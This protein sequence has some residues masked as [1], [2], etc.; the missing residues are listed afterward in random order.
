M[1]I[2]IF[3]LVLPFLLLS[4]P[5][6]MAVKHVE[7][8]SHLLCSNWFDLKQIR[9]ILHVDKIKEYREVSLYVNVKWLITY[10][11]R[12]RVL[13]RNCLPFV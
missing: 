3:G 13:M 11:S 1:L 8:M 12:L 2:Q 4:L 10:Y 9:F 6:S 7:S 5:L